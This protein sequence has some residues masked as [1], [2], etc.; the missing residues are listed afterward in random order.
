MLCLAE[1]GKCG[2]TQGNPYIVTYIYI[3]IYACKSVIYLHACIVVIVLI[4]N[5]LK[6]HAFEALACMEMHA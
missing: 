3:Y 4:P 2:K 1:F 6:A 5:K